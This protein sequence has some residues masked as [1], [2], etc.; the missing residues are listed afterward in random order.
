MIIKFILSISILFLYGCAKDKIDEVS[1]EI[2]GRV[3]LIDPGHGGSDNGASYDGVLEDEINLTI[4]LELQK[5]LLENGAIALMTRNGDYDLSNMYDKNHKSNDLK[6]RVNII[7]SYNVDLFISLHLNMYKSDSVSGA[8]VFYQNDNENS[9]NFASILQ[10]NINELY[11]KK[12]KVM[13]GNYYIL[14]KSEKVGVLVEMGFLSSSKDRAK[15]LN[16]NY[17]ILISNTIYNSIKEYF[18]I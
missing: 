18:L 4:A 17:Q 7:N 3:I 5:V 8:Q 2:T 13:K 15:L 12:R 9:F 6:N 16:K 1:N 11:S 14:E 10:K